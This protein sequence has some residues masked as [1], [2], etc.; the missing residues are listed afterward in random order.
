MAHR[1][2]CLFLPC[3]FALANSNAQD[4]LVQKKL[5]EVDSTYRYKYKSLDSLQRNFHHRTDSLRKAYATPMNKIQ[6][7]I[8]R[9]NHKKDS[10]NGIHLQTKGVTHLIDSLQNAN[11]AK[12]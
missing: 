9:L 1:L 6:S 7:S 5:G 11:T 8:N 12:L 10:L 2:L 3:V 4:S